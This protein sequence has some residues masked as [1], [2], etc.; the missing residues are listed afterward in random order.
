MEAIRLKP[1]D[2]DAYHNRAHCY[3]RLGEYARAIE[4]FDAVLRLDPDNPAS[5]SRDAAYR[6]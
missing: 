6:A 3:F 1:D 4:D 5:Q 2:D